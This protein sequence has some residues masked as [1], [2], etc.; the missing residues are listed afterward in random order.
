MVA[1]EY[2]WPA[3][4]RGTA[5]LFEPEHTH[6]VRNSRQQIRIILAAVAESTSSRLPMT[7]SVYANDIRRCVA[8]CLRISVPAS[9][10]KTLRR[11]RRSDQQSS[12]GD[13][14]DHARH[15]SRRALLHPRSRPGA[16][17]PRT[18]SRGAKRGAHVVMGDGVFGHRGAWR[19]RGRLHDREPAGVRSYPPW[20][21]SLAAAVDS[22]S[23][24][25]RWSS[26][27]LTRARGRA[28][29]SLAGARCARVLGGI[30]AAVECRA[31][32]TADHE[33]CTHVDARASSAHT[34]ASWSGRAGGAAV[35]V[36]S[37]ST[38]G[39]CS[40]ELLL[41]VGAC[42]ALRESMLWTLTVILLL[43]WVVG[44]ATSSQLGA[45]VH[46]LLVLAIISIAINLIRGRSTN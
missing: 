16:D 42:L 10:V 29:R 43:L 6:A 15:C 20:A 44:L 46:I 19:L 30:L 23:N 40:A 18:P 22:S 45:W 25:G 12:R 31:R 27:R 11:A 4:S 1:T 41:P 7:R 8:A 13:P 39:R 34:G 26:A 3:R 2:H 9:K 37:P 32:R 5:R 14:I 38:R 35:D 17:A 24:V 21:L 28:S 36:G 33:K